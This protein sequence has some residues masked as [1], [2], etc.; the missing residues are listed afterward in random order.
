MG[1]K[2][3]NSIEGGALGR[4]GKKTAFSL[5]AP[6]SGE[7]P[8]VLSQMLRRGKGGES[9]LLFLEKGSENFLSSFYER[10]ELYFAGG[11]VL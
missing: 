11:G 4:G 3:W 7:I 1:G 6:P 5:S 9:F 2:R 8:F 10:G